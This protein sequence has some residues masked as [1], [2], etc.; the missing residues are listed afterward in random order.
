MSKSFKLLA[1]LIGSLAVTMFLLRH[2]HSDP[3][4]WI[5]VA[6]TMIVIYL[7]F[8]VPSIGKF[9]AVRPRITFWSGVVIATMGM[10]SL[11]ALMFWSSF[12]GYPKGI[13]GG[14][15]ISFA[16]MYIFMLGIAVTVLPRGVLTQKRFERLLTK[17]KS[18]LPEGPIVG[19]LR[20]GGRAILTTVYRILPFFRLAG[21]W[22]VIVWL[23][24]LLGLYLVSN[25]SGH[26]INTLVTSTDKGAVAATFVATY[27]CFVLTML[28]ALPTVLVAWHRYILENKLPRFVLPSPNWQAMRYLFRLWII[29]ILFGILVRIAFTNGPDLAKLLRIKDAALV[30]GSLFWSALVI[31]IYLGSSYALVFPA[32]ALGNRQFVSMDSLVMI[33]RSPR[34]FRLGFIFSLLPL[35]LAWGIYAMIDR[36]WDQSDWLLRYGLRAIPLT[37]LFVSFGSCATYISRVY[38]KGRTATTNDTGAALALSVNPA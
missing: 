9:I 7:P 19:G 35:T 30:S 4:T 22:I 27:F 21:V 2:V 28:V 13:T 16:M 3:G 38:E 12:Y 15:P 32:I 11:F 26:S 34:A 10:A 20:E 18:Q 1:A 25:A 8:G 36:L 23:A 14:D 5:G 24:P 6:L 37:L 31:E 33:K 17:P 29:L